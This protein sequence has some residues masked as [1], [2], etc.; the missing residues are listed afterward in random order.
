M[1]DELQ[2]VFASPE[3]PNGAFRRTAIEA[4]APRG[5]AFLPVV[6][7]A[8]AELAQDLEHDDWKTREQA[9]ART[10]ALE[11]VKV[12]ILLDAKRPLSSE[13]RT[14]LA[15]QLEMFYDKDRDVLAEILKT[16]DPATRDEIFENVPV[17][18]KEHRNVLAL[19]HLAPSTLPKVI[20]ATAPLETG[21]YE[22]RYIAAH[23]RALAAFGP[24]AATAIVSAIK[25][26]KNDGA[27]SLA[28]AL[29]TIATP[30]IA[31]DLVELLGHN[32]KGVRLAAASA[33]QRLGT[34][35]KAALE[36]GAQSKKKAVREAALE[37]LS[38]LTAEKSRADELL[39]AA[40]PLRAEILADFDAA[41]AIG[42][43]PFGGIPEK[44]AAR[45]A[46]ALAA[47]HDWM[48]ERV[49]DWKARSV[50]NRTFEL[51]MKDPDAVWVY[52]KLF[53]SLPKLSPYTYRELVGRM[54]RVEAAALVPP[55]VSVLNGPAFPLRAPLFELLSEAGAEADDLW[56]EALGDASKEIR[57]YAIENL[58]KRGPDIATKILPH[59][60]SKSADARAAAAQVLA[61][62]HASSEEV[63][64]A[65]AGALAVE[66]KA[67]VAAL[68]ERALPK[69]AAAEGAAIQKKES[70]TEDSI[71]DL[72]AKER[73]ARL[74][75]WLDPTKLP[76]LVTKSGRALEAD[77]LL[78]FLTRLMNEGP[79]LEDAV[80]RRVRPFLDDASARAF[81]NAIR[82]TWRKNKADAKHKWAVYQQAILADEARLDE[83]GPRLD[84]V[85]SGGD[86]HLA[87]WYV[88]A[89]ARHSLFSGSNRG[90]SW[91]AHWAKAA[92]TNA[93]REKANAA[94]AA[95]ATAR[96][97]TPAELEAEL[98]AYVADDV[99][100]AGILA[101]ESETLDFGARTFTLRLGSNL[102][103]VLETTDGKRLE[104]LPAPGNKDDAASAKAAK[105]RFTT[106]KKTLE[107]VV[108]TETQRLETAMVSGRPWSTAKWTKLFVEHPLMRVLGSML[109]FT[110]GTSFFRPDGEGKG[111]LDVA[112]RRVTLAND[113]GIRIAHR[114]DL[115]DDDARAWGDVF[116]EAKIIQP[117]DQI[118]R[119]VHPR[120]NELSY[121]TD[122]VSPKTLA[123]RLRG[124]G[125][126]HGSVQDAGM[127]YTAY[128]S[129]PARGAKV[130]LG[131]EG[132][133]VS[134]NSWATD[135]VG[136][137]DVWFETRTGEKIEPGNVDPIVFSEVARDLA[138]LVQS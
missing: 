108:K 55:L 137:T 57:G 122:K 10:A 70:D 97:I 47:A 89:L 13:T 116:G 76:P 71:F 133:H 125:W 101:L 85:T 19:A 25:D 135:P 58:S 56:A 45:G 129:F 18:T 49:N 103:L 20:A 64:A 72:L 7:A 110:D 136:I 46:V 91:V 2:E 53:A 3:F 21:K 42:S 69:E 74:P 81:S 61:K 96:G 88:D 99:A 16:V 115:S 54:K 6:D 105:Q 128:R 134:D 24:S 94:F 59:L 62:I 98:D 50:Y 9:S 79:E 118:G 117:F 48:K 84:E 11:M 73:R 75:T 113:A 23:A 14:I 138:Y 107:S 130:V 8:I 52:V 40:A 4:L 41:L 60:A 38:S 68:L 32:V 39:A 82:E 51:L 114:L 124:A 112:G 93:L 78:A 30:E 5:E 126:R 28:M 109:V 77:V 33:L 132:V 15:K 83:V 92:E 35:A 121:S 90:L 104:K 100:D 131:H 22:D 102:E 12:R 87:R 66:K 119:T 80:A 43:T 29:E 120:M 65:V 1:H 106:V 63:R 127:V 27:T 44:L 17:R 36:K 31:G 26:A 111:V 95:A 123:G 34:P 37:I 67:D 86:H